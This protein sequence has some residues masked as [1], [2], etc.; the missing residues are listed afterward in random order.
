MHA[1]EMKLANGKVRRDRISILIKG[2]K[3]PDG[4]KLKPPEIAVLQGKG[5]A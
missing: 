4:Y 2:R 3:L 5:F 1:I